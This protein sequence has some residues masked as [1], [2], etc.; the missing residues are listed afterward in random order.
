MNRKSEYLSHIINLKHLKVISCYKQTWNGQWT[1]KVLRIIKKK[2]TNSAQNVM[3]EEKEWH[4]R[5]TLNREY[6][7]CS[8]ELEISDS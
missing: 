7:Q 6:F 8:I 5:I 1:V 3:E 2:P 4:N